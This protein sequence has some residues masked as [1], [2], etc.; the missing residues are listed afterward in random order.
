MAYTC[1]HLNR[2]RDVLSGCDFNDGGEDNIKRP[3]LREVDRHSHLKV[4]PDQCQTVEAERKRRRYRCQSNEDEV[5]V[6]CETLIGVGKREHTGNNS[7]LLP[8]PHAKTE[9]EAADSDT[10]VNVSIFDGIAWM[11]RGGGHLRETETGVSKKP[12]GGCIGV[13]FG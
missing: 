7:W 10:F 12:A 4:V 6:R 3:S 8:Q 1:E 11:D 2:E 13:C 5:R 9:M